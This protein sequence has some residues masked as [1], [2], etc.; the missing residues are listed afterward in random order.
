[1]ACAIR[2]FQTLGIGAGDGWLVRR[3]HWHGYLLGLAPEGGPLQLLLLLFCRVRRRDAALPLAIEELG[4]LFVDPLL[5]SRRRI[6]T[7]DIERPVL[8]EIEITVAAAGLAPSGKLCVAFDQCRRL[9][10]TGRRLFGG[11]GAFLKNR[12]ARA[13]PTTPRGR[14]AMSAPSRRRSRP[15]TTRMCVASDLRFNSQ[16]EFR[17]HNLSRLSSLSAGLSPQNRRFFPREWWNSLRIPTERVNSCPIKE[18]PGSWRPDES[19]CL[20]NPGADFG[21]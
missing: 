8:H 19:R 6:R 17:R 14:A 15:S 21:D 1:M 7:C 5:L 10:F 4:I 18:R 3:W 9:R 20:I 2:G 12:P 13:C 16:H 11:V